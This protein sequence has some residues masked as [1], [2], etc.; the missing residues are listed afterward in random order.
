[1]SNK[2]ETFIKFKFF[3][4]LIKGETKWKIKTLRFDHGGE[5]TSIEFN[6]YC[7]KN[8]IKQ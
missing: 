4:K 1:M 5:F 2:A 6:N 8:E 3:K 7:I